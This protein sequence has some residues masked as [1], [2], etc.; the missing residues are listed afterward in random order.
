MSDENKG[1]FKD[2]GYEPDA[3]ILAGSRKGEDYQVL[4]DAIQ[5]RIIGKKVTN[6]KFSKVKADFGINTVN[7]QVQGKTIELVLEVEGDCAYI[8]RVE[9]IIK[10][11]G[12]ALANIKD[13]GAGE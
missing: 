3:L 11:S 4:Q 13:E 10:D 7:G 1:L 5:E 12:E 6:L 2:M 9:G 8:L